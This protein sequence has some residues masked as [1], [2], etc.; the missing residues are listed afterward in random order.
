M[1]NSKFLPIGTI[2]VLKNNDKEIMIAGYYSIS[3]NG[4][5][6]LYDYSGVVYPE[7]LLMQNRKISFNHSDIEKISFMGYINDNYKKLNDKLNSNDSEYNKEHNVDNKVTYNFVFD[8]NGVVI[9]DPIVMEKNN[10]NGNSDISN[11]KN[12]LRN[13]FQEKYDND[14]KNNNNNNNK[15]SNWSIFKNNSNMKE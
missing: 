2:C 10:N 4:V 3:Y 9:F 5:V 6:K 13:P 11:E 8:E 15:N 1:D 7:G 14:L 12:E